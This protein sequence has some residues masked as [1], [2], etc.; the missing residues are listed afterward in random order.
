M[1]KSD[2]IYIPAKR[3]RLP[4]KYREGKPMRGDRWL[5]LMLFLCALCWFGIYE[6]V[7]R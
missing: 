7:K 5:A 3:G 6:W 1:D 4:R 2:R